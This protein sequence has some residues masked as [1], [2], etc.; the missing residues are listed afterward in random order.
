MSGKPSLEEERRGD[1]RR[2][3]IKCASSG[4]IS[5]DELKR[6]PMSIL[7]RLGSTLLSDIAALG[8]EAR[9][10]LGAAASEAASFAFME[11]A[12]RL[13]RRSKR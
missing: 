5:L 13:T 7:A 11:I 9:D 8:D 3:L 2:Y 4:L 6:S 10:G 1:L 12:Q